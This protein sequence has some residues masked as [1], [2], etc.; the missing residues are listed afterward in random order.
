ML[1]VAPALAGLFPEGGIRRGST[2][3]VPSSPSLVMALIAEPSARGIWS[4]IVGLPD[5]GLVAAAEAGID[6]TGAIHV[7]TRQRRRHS[8]ASTSS[9]EQ[10]P[11]S[12]PLRGPPRE[13]RPRGALPPSRPLC[14]RRGAGQR[15]AP[16]GASRGRTTLTR[17][18]RRQ[19]SRPPRKASRHHPGA[20]QPKDERARGTTSVDHDAPRPPRAPQQPT[21]RRHN[22]RTLIMRTAPE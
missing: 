19:S 16:A 21:N 8:P 7:P 17:D 10:P 15:G 18:E 14:R 3:R 22:S 12:S 5:F 4:A 20:S 9:T 11:K 1:P 6:L 13:F 2:I